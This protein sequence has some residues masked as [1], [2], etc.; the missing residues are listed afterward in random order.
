MSNCDFVADGS[1]IDL[2]ASRLALR[3]PAL[4]AASAL[5]Q[6]NQSAQ[7]LSGDRH[8]V[9]T[10]KEVGPNDVITN[11]GIEDGNHL[12]HDRNDHDLRHLAS[13][14]EALTERLEHW[15][16]IARAHRGH[17]E[18]FTD[19]RTTAPDAT[20]SFKLATLERIGCDTNQCSDLFAAHCAELG[21]QRHQ[22]AGQHQS[23]SW[24]RGERSVA[25]GERSIAFH[26]RGQVAVEHVDVGRKPC[27]A[28]PR[29][30]LQHRIFQQSR[31]ILNGNFL[32]V[33]LTANRQHLGQPF[34]PGRARLRR[35]CRHDGDK[36]R[37]HAGIE[38][39]VLGQNPA[40]A[41][42]LAQ[43]ER[44]DLA[45][46]QAG[47]QQGAHRPALV[48]SAG[49]ETDCRDRLVGVKRRG[50]SALRPGTAGA[51]LLAFVSVGVA[52]ALRLAIHPYVE[53]LQFAT[54]LP[55]VVITTLISGLGAGLFSVVLSVAAAA[56][57][58]L[59]PSL[60]FYIEK[61]G[62][63]LALLLYTVVMLFTVALITG[64]R[65]VLT[66]LISE[67]R[68]RNRDAQQGDQW[69]IRRSQC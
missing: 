13:A 40:G 62:D 12:A 3:A 11:H 26:D 54:F 31:G 48:A 56:F 35:S 42:E 28:T 50:D 2:V 44:V 18:H 68:Q 5:T 4:S 30:P 38:R 63:V 67:K 49:L 6:P 25:M 53:G 21:Q 61:P 8:G 52:T 34:D 45:S 57:F 9:P 24:H 39:T 58:V 69:R 59:P 33:E 36:R 66:S 27:D 65:R 64:M 32:D 15:I 41:G 29:K 17:V 16:P 46:R 60:S 14:L 43:L 10:V 7:W 23:N 19:G 22:R 55:A 37:D 47:C 51:Y 1:L 20:P